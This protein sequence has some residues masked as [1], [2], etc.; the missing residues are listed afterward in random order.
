MREGEK[1]RMREGKKE[2]RREG[3]KARRIEGNKER[4]R[5]GEKKTMVTQKEIMPGRPIDRSD[6]STTC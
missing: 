3:E 4:R 5:E 1:G 2:R 6:R